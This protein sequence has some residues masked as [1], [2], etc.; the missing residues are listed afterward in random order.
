MN[1]Q[2]LPNEPI[3]LLEFYRA[4]EIDEAQNMVAETALSMRG[5]LFVISDLSEADIRFQDL[6]CALTD[7]GHS[8]VFASSHKF[9]PILVDSSGKHPAFGFRNREQAIAYARSMLRQ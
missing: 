5:T 1:G 4:S 2:K 8:P 7:I 9:I 3:L 6:M